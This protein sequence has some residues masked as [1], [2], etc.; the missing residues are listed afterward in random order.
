M[1][2]APSLLAGRL[3]GRPRPG[4]EG[5]CFS[6]LVQ[7][8]MVSCCFA[9]VV[10]VLML[11]S[12]SW[13]TAPAYGLRGDGPATP[14]PLLQSSG[15]RQRAARRTGPLPAGRPVLPLT[16]GR[17]D[18]LLLAFST[19]LTQASPAAP[20][21]D[22][23]RGATADP[24]PLNRLL[25]QYGEAL[26]AAGKPYWQYAETINAVV[27]ACPV[28]RRLLPQAW[29]LGFAWVAA[30]PSE[31]HAA[32]TLPLF[33]ACLA[34]ALLWGWPRIA[35][36]L[37]L[38]WGALLRPGELLQARRSDLHLPSDSGGLVDYALL[39]IAEPKT[40]FRGARHQVAKLDAPDLVELVAA[41]FA[42]LPPCARL[43]PASAP[44]FRLRFQAILRALHLPYARSSSGSRHFEVASLRAGGA[45]HLYMST[46]DGEFVRRRGRW[47]SGKTM[48]IYVQEVAAVA[49]L[50]SLPLQTRERVLRVG[51][52]AADLTV[53]SVQ[54]LRTGVPASCWPGYWAS[55]TSSRT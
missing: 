4:R 38:G 29:D 23:L 11:C 6:P 47:A 41:V 30:E 35:G 24:L 37:A 17:R 40:R 10:A 18:R 8:G 26:W 54:L 22:L 13:Q 1:R 50:G 21:A 7:H 45:T 48:D 36:L 3:G 51:A 9:V 19:W 46:E 53:A 44:A 28:L 33:S 52:A 2:P 55:P 31:H 32:L 14:S 34:V 12:A 16:E 42:G 25:V 20:L 15:D 5:R 43:W 49:V 39:A 27:S